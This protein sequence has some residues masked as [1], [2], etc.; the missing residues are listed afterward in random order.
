MQRERMN[1]QHVLLLLGRKRVEMPTQPIMGLFRL[2]SLFSMQGVVEGEDKSDR[3]QY[4]E[5]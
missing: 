4:V 1:L 3:V 5:Q 2:V